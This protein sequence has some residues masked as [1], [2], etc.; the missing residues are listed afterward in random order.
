MNLFISIQFRP[1][2]ECS[3]VT[4]YGVLGVMRPVGEISLTVL[5][6]ALWTLMPFAEFLLSLDCVVKRRTR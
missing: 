5:Q 6:V 1:E 4:V 2:N 3:Y